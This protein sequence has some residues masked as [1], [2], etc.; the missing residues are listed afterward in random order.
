MKKTLPRYFDHSLNAFGKNAVS[1]DQRNNLGDCG[2]DRVTAHRPF[3]HR[4]RKLQ[5]CRPELTPLHGNLKISHVSLILLSQSLRDLDD[6]RTHGKRGFKSP[7]EITI[8]VALLL[9][10]L[11]LTSDLPTHTGIYRLL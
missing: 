11:R 6:A 10:P 3:F 7:R 9:V 8:F 5:T 2:L 4:D 1:R